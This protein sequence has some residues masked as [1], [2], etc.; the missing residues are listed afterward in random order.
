MRDKQND[1]AVAEPTA[2]LKSSFAGPETGFVMGG[3]C[4][5][6]NSGRGLRKSIPKSYAQT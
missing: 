6:R 4:I 3:C 2:A 1:D 5:G